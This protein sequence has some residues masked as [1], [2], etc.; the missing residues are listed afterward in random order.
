MYLFFYKPIKASLTKIIITVQLK[1]VKILSKKYF[2]R[3]RGSEN[4]SVMRFFMDYYEKWNV[5]YPLLWTSQQEEDV[6]AAILCYLTNKSM[7]ISQRKRPPNF[8][9]PFP[10]TSA[11]ITSKV[12]K[13]T[14]TDSYLNWNK[15]H[16]VDFFLVLSQI[17]M[18]DVE[19][20]FCSNREM[21]LSGERYWRRHITHLIVFQTR[22][23]EKV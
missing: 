15:K 2:N 16:F 18:T 5:L 1:I 3:V 14:I 19:T 10:S 11:H 7:E 13:K 6:L 22:L 12:L 20:T 17:C 23:P 9:D 21:E 8:F 4:N